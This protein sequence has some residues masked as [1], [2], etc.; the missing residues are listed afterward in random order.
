MA[1]SSLQWSAVVASFADDPEVEVGEGRGFGAGALK[2]KGKIF[3]FV[4]AKGDFVVKLPKARADRLF[5]EGRAKAF[6]PGHGRLMKQWAAVVGADADLIALA[7]EARAFVG[8]S[9]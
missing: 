7:R 8:G 6:D 5:A 2:A 4:S 1:R 9:K 3:A